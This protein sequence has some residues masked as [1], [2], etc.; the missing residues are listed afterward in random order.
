MSTP[1]KTPSLAARLLDI[2][3]VIGAL[4]GI[5]GILLTLAGLFPSL[6]VRREHTTN[7]SNVV[8]LSVGTGANLCVGL[9]MLAIALTFAA[10]AIARP[11]VV[12]DH[13][14]DAS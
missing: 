12:G 10:W 9:I 5:Y 1:T 2:R 6:F 11:Q 4:L 7:N 3:S 14:D 13:V 8:D